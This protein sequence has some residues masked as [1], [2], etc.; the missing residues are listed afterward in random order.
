MEF[1]WFCRQLGEQWAV[2]TEADSPGALLY[3]DGDFIPND[4]LPDVA[5]GC[6]GNGPS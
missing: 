5:G 1:R 2:D 3:E 6:F 4:R